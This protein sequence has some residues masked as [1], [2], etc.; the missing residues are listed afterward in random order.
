MNDYNNICI[1]TCVHLYRTHFSVLLTLFVMLLVFQ[2][3]GEDSVFDA[4]VQDVSSRC[5]SIDLPWLDTEIGLANIQQTAK[6]CSQLNNECE[7]P[8]SKRSDKRRTSTVDD[9][10]ELAGASCKP[11]ADYSHLYIYK[12]NSSSAASQS[13]K[14]SEYIALSSSSSSD[15]DENSSW[16][17]SVADVG[18]FGDTLTA[19][20]AAVADITPTVTSVH[21]AKYL[22]FYRSPNTG[23][24]IANPNKKR[25]KN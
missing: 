11:V 1:V 14:T 7:Q 24:Q 12:K 18:S 23:I 21:S 5:P 16:L 17:V 13:D 20:S 22:K 6:K 8:D 3:L 25:K 10:S 15:E 4:V 9:S 19:S 2:K